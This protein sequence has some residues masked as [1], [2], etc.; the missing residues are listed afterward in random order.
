MYI[1]FAEFYTDDDAELVY[2]GK[3]YCFY[4]DKLEITYYGETIKEC[5]EHLKEIKVTPNFKASNMIQKIIDDFLD[6]NELETSFYGNQEIDIYI[7][8][9]K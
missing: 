5:K 6:S 4:S 8:K 1:L 3:S 9:I 2:K 7:R